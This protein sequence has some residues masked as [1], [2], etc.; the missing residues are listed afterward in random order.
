MRYDG[1]S[2]IID[3]L[4]KNIYDKNKFNIKVNI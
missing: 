3:P 4:Y 2:N 1:L